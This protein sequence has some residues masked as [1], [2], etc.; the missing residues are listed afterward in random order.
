MRGEKRWRS[1]CVLF[2][3]IVALLMVQIIVL[4]LSFNGWLKPENETL[5]LWIQRAGSIVVGLSF[6][7]TLVEAKAQTTIF[8][9]MAI[10]RKIGEKHAQNKF[11][12]TVIGLFFRKFLVWSDGVMTIIGTF[13]WGYGD[14]LFDLLK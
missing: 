11:F 14:L 8:P 2:S 5:G 1:F 7:Q 12:N 4:V 10:C 13:A 3:V 9:S 6:L